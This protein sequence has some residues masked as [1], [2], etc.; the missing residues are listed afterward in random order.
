MH[1]EGIESYQMNVYWAMY[2]S[3]KYSMNSAEEQ[4]QTMK[5]NAEIASNN[6]IYPMIV[7][8]WLRNFFTENIVKN[9][10]IAKIIDKMAKGTNIAF[11]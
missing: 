6:E 2:S 11:T 1:A 8:G 10:K 5:L 4:I 9:T 3:P 7:F